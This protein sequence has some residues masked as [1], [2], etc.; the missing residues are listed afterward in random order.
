[1]L[2]SSVD[3]RNA[4][5]VPKETERNVVKTSILECEQDRE[6]VATTGIDEMLLMA[7][8]QY[9]EQQGILQVLNDEQRKYDEVEIL[10]TR[11]CARR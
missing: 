6:E 4:Y 7:S 2:S 3:K 5:C 1:M 9:K 8:Q 11:L 10:K